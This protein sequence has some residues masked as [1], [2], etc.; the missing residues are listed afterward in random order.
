PPTIGVQQNVLSKGIFN[1]FTPACQETLCG[2]L[3]ALRTSYVQSHTEHHSA[4][5]SKIGFLPT[6]H[7]ICIAPL[8]TMRLSFAMVLPVIAALASLT[9]ASPSD[10]GAKKCP[11]FCRHT[12]QCSACPVV[13]CVSFGGLS[14]RFNHIT[15]QHCSTCLYVT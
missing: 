4:Y 12:R 8:H 3:L 2:N 6:L 7:I 1:C 13:S 10:A 11:L 9:S 15:H 5:K 14:P